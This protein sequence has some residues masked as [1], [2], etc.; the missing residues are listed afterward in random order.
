MRKIGILLLAFVLTVGLMT[1]C[2]GQNNEATAPGT[3]QPTMT[4]PIPADTEP[5]TDTTSG[6]DLIP[7]DDGN[8]NIGGN[9]GN[10]GGDGDGGN[11]MDG[12][13]GGN[14]GGANGGTGGNEG[15]GGIG[16][17]GGTGG[18]GSSG[19][20]STSEGPSRSRRSY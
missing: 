18:T 9:G 1:A 3:E 4:S 2:R 13:I 20:S 8:G 19:L 7:G 6:T 12:G 5:S 15:N 11:G 10:N 16:G 14:N 17:S